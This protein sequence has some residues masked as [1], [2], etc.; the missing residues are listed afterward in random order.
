[1]TSFLIL[2]ILTAAQ[3][4]PKKDLKTRL[5][6]D[7][8]KMELNKLEEWMHEDSVVVTEPD[9]KGY[10]AV[11]SG[12]VQFLDKLPAS[13][14]G[15]DK[16]YVKQNPAGF[17]FVQTERG[18]QF[19]WNRLYWHPDEK[20]WLP[21]HPNYSAFLR[22]NSQAHWFMDK[23]ANAYD[24]KAGVNLPPLVGIMGT[25]KTG[26][27]DAEKE[28]KFKAYVRAVGDSWGGTE[29]VEQAYRLAI[30][31]DRS[32]GPSEKVELARKR[33]EILKQI[34]EKVDK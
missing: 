20:E 29:L 31:I 23:L 22:E 33:R 1:M 24:S 15:I 17:A 27:D 7:L 10:K 12:E 9:S 30:Q 4:K 13:P 6:E 2:S 18:R 32:S 28:E 19:V 11:V 26:K 21:S 3:S 16:L 34:A 8:A 5:K 25:D 14:D